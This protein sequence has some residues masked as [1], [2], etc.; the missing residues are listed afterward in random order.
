MHPSRACHPSL[1]SRPDEK[2]PNDPEKILQFSLPCACSQL[3]AL[4][5]PLLGLLGARLFRGPRVIRNLGRLV[6]EDCMQGQ[7]SLPTCTLD[8]AL[9]F[10]SQGQPW[11]PCGLL[12]G[13]P[14]LDV[15]T[16]PARSS[17]EETSLGELLPGSILSDSLKTKIFT[18]SDGLWR[19]RGEVNMCMFGTGKVDCCQGLLQS[20][21][22]GIL[23][24]LLQI[25]ATSLQGPQGISMTTK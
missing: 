5:L 24:G 2:G 21:N 9:W 15:A 17:L 14:L 19:L 16:I 1:G 20:R 7:L 3:R 18:R 8:Y 11:Q 22:P 23:Q 12:A 4:V 13:L 10:H 25:T 6:Q